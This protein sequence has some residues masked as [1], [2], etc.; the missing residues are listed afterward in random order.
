MKAQAIRT[1]KSA[2]PASRA[3]ATRSG[4]ETVPNSGP[5]KMAARFSAPPS[6]ASPG[7]AHAFDVSAFGADEIARPGSERG[8]GDLVFLVRLLDAGGLEVLQD[9]LGKGLLL[10]VASAGFRHTVDQFVV[11]IHPQHR[12]GERLST[13]NGPATRTFFLSS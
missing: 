11:L 7:I 9:H 13:V 8:E 2:S 12:C 10:A 6:P 3:A 4:R 5:M 1:S